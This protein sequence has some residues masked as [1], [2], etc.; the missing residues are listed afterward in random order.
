TP[1]SG[2]PRTPRWR[3]GSWKATAPPLVH[4]WAGKAP[5]IKRVNPTTASTPR[6][7]DIARLAVASLA[8]SARVLDG[9]TR[10]VAESYQRRVLEAAEELGYT[11]NLSAPS[12]ARGTA[13]IIALLVADIADPFFSNIAAGVA[14]M[15]DEAGLVVTIATTS[16]DPA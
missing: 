4:I 15:A 11:A 5:R 14:R 9:V 7:A 8:S 16:R 1:T 12:T 10:Q 2:T 13:G 6:L 3:G